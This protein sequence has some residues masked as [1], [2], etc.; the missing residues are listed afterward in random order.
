MP[1][2][3]IRPRLHTLH[4]NFGWTING[5]ELD[6]L[7]LDSVHE[8][9]TMSIIIAKCEICVGQISYDMAKFG[10]VILFRHHQQFSQYYIIRL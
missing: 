9:V 2:L 1:S 4:E 6:T 8:A 5:I 10:H 3:A 7:T